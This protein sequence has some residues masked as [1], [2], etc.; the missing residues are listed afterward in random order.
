MIKGFQA[1]GL[2]SL[3]MILSFAAPFLAR[4]PFGPSALAQTSV[5]K[6]SGESRATKEARKA[7]EEPGEGECDPAD[8]C[9]R[10]SSV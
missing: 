1:I 8:P 7:V 3:A 4:G 9:T 2:I 10:I 5:T 6:S